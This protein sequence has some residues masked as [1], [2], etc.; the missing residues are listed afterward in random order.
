MYDF[1]YK[2]AEEE[3]FP[4]IQSDLEGKK[5]L[6]FRIQIMSILYIICHEVGHLYNG[7]IGYNKMAFMQEIN[8]LSEKKRNEIIFRKT[9]ELDADAFAMNRMLEYNESLIKVKSETKNQLSQYES[10]EYSYKILLFSMYSFYLFLGETFKKELIKKS[11]YFSPA[12]RQLLNL[13]IAREFVAK[14][15]PEFINEIDGIID[16]LLLHG[17]FM[18]DKFKSYKRNVK[19]EQKYILNKL[20]YFESMELQEEMLLVSKHWNLIR[21]DLQKNARVILSPEYQL[22]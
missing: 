17:D 18:M 22:D 16:Y 4:E 11:T 1:Y 5:D 12:I 20:I 8:K 15:R 13:T 7:H 6:V 19:D 2:V 10:I 21:N 3:I 9:I 14:K